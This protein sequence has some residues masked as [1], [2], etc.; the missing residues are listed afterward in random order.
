MAIHCE[1]MSY[2]LGLEHGIK[3]S[4]DKVARS[5]LA[6]PASKYIDGGADP[7][8]SMAVSVGMRC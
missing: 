6:I 5:L 4:F 3:L 1:Y 2:K 7:C 8:H